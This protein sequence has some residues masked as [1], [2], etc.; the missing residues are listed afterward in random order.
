MLS[1][2]IGAFIGIVVGFVLACYWQTA[3]ATPAPRWRMTT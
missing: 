2:L 1:F 3:S